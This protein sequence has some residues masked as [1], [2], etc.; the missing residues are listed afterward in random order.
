[1][2]IAAQAPGI[3]DTSPL[4]STA[5]LCSA[6]SSYLVATVWLTEVKSRLPRDAQ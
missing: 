6:K 3:L 4:A 2:N 1:M 5:T